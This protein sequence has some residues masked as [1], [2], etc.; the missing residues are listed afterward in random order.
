MGM[1]YLEIHCEGYKGNKMK[2]IFGIHK[3]ADSFA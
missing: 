2:R 3:L 1:L